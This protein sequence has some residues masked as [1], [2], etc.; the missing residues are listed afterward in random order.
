MLMYDNYT[1]L[2]R[3]SCVVNYID[4]RDALHKEAFHSFNLNNLRQPAEQ[5]LS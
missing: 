1:V 2:Y 3:T 4:G 5:R